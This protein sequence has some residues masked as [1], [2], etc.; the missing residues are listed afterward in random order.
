MPARLV[1]PKTVLRS[2]FGVVRT[3]FGAILDKIDENNQKA[4]RNAIWK[5][6]GAKPEVHHNRRLLDIAALN[7][8]GSFVI[9]VPDIDN[10]HKVIMLTFNN[11]VQDAARLRRVKFATAQLTSKLQPLLRLIGSHF[12]DEEAVMLRFGFPGIPDHIRQHDQ[13]MC[14]VLAMLE[15]ADTGAVG[16]EQIIFVIG[17]WI[18]G[19]ILISDKYF[20]DYLMS[21]EGADFAERL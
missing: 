12:S 18:S 14:D 4:A 11:L 9:G 13:F 16:F 8:D 19:H 10:Q 21:K 5:T 1:K 6:I 7:F 20:G 3:P 2:L 17:A 15:E